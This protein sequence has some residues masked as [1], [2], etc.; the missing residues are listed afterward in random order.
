MSSLSIVETSHQLI[1]FDWAVHHS[2]MNIWL[3]K[4]HYLHVLSLEIESADE[5]RTDFLRHHDQDSCS[6]LCTTMYSEFL[7]SQR[8]TEGLVT[9]RKK[10]E[11]NNLSLYLNGAK[12]GEY[13]KGYWNLWNVHCKSEIY[14]NKSRKP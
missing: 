11:K 6:I 2:I 8:M 4:H 13:H 14:V 10:E 12:Q 1:V 3:S 5:Y 9:T 7:F